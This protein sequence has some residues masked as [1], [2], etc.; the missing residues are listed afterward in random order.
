MYGDENKGIK[1]KILIGVGAVLIVAIIV[2]V[3][4]MLT[5]SKLTGTWINQLNRNS[6]YEFSSGGKGAYIYLNTRNEF[7]YETDGDKLI[8]TYS[9]DSVYEFTYKLNNN[10]LILKQ[11][12]GNTSIFVKKK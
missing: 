10:K 8:I 4:L 1:K 2:V 5:K 11:S 6:S 12:S 7:K 9:N 3:I